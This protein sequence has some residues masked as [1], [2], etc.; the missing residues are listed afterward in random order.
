MNC[1][2]LVHPSDMVSRFKISTA[3]LPGYLAESAK[4][5]K[6]LGR[7]CKSPRNAAV[8]AGYLGAHGQGCVGFLES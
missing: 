2:R 7:I 4:L 1:Q 5:T 8:Q 6:L 3:I